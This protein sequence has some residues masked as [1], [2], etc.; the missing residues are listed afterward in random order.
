MT[1]NLTSSTQI[2][3][4]QAAGTASFS[5]TIADK[6]VLTYIGMIGRRTGLPRRLIAENL[7]KSGYRSAKS[8][9]PAVESEA[10]R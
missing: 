1:K 7:L 8:V 3:G 2:T 10:A 4:A 6:D 5:L 9:Y